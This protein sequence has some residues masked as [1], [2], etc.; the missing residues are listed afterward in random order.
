MRVVRK[1]SAGLVMLCLGSLLG[2]AYSSDDLTAK[3]AAAGDAAKHNA[4]AVIVL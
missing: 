1:T 3:I 4:D 2:P